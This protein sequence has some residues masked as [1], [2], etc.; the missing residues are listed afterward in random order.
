M[1]RWPS[2]QLRLECPPAEGAARFSSHAGQSTRSIYA[3]Q[4]LRYSRIA[5]ILAEPSVSCMSPQPAAP[6]STV[7]GKSPDRRWSGLFGRWAPSP[8]YRLAGWL[9]RVAVTCAQRCLSRAPRIDSNDQPSASMAA[10]LPLSYGG[11]LI[12]PIV[13]RRR[14]GTGAVLAG[15]Q[16]SCPPRAAARWSLVGGRIAARRA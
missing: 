5:E 15:G 11:M 10:T 13:P 2:T 16:A 3:M 4:P 9:L 6:R 7:H 1:C 14:A 12:V 8:V